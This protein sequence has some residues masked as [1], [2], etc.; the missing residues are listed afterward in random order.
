MREFAA[1]R[2]NVRFVL[3]LGTELYFSMMR[4]SAAMMGN[5]SSGIIEAAGFRLPVVNIGERQQG[6]LKPRNVI[7]CEA[8]QA[9]IAAALEKALS[10]RFRESLEG[11]VNPY[12]DG[13]AAARITDALK[14]TEINDKL[15][16]KRFVDTKEDRQ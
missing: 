11:L 15:I 7:D 16:R 5:S 10:P 8:D 1:T 2:G 4:N 9:S 6:R 12:G 13:H 3:N 14:K